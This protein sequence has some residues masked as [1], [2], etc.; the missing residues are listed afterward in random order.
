M[1]LRRDAEGDIVRRNF[2]FASNAP[3]WQLKI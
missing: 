1:P 2:W 3:Y